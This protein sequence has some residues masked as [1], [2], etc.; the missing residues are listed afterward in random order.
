MLLKI[1]KILLLLF[2]IFSI[3]IS[4]TNSESLIVL[5][6]KS[7]PLYTLDINNNNNN[8]SLNNN[9]NSI[10]FFNDY[11]TFRLFSPVKIGSPPQNVISFINPIYEHLLIGELW[12]IQ[13]G[14]YSDSFYIGYQYN[15]SSSFINISSS[16]NDSIYYDKNKDIFIG[17]ENLYL[18]TN[19]NDIKDQKLTSFSN[20]KFRFED[21]IKYGI[22]KFLHI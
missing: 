13:N 11:Y 7:I 22:I 6:F 18:Y 3:I 2:K 16:R 4:S 1:S 20:F 19:I 12:D 10:N 14:I 5:P 21:L 15:K 8:K 9:Y 17:E